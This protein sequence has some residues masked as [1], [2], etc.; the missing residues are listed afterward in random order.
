MNVEFFWRNR[1]CLLYIFPTIV[2]SSKNGLFISFRWLS[3]SLL[4]YWNL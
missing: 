4:I 3:T 2:I 1:D